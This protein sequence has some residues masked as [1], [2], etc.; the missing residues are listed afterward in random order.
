M[1]C[2]QKKCVPDSLKLSYS[3]AFLI[4]YWTL[5]IASGSSALSIS[6]SSVVS[7]PYDFAN[8]DFLA[9]SKNL[10]TYLCTISAI[11]HKLY[12]TI[13]HILQS[14]NQRYN[15]LIWI[16]ANFDLFTYAYFMHKSTK[17]MKTPANLIVSS[18]ACLS[19]CGCIY[20]NSLS[21]SSIPASCAIFL[22]SLNSSSASSSPTY[23][24]S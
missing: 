9:P 10:R 6:Y 11:R 21:S 20:P 24:C 17:K 8:F 7:L 4:C 12:I 13:N 16:M 1:I 15:S 22:R 5:N 18:T 19:A 23:T 14:K 3:A 2:K